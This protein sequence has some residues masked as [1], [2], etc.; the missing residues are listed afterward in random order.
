[1]FYVILL[2]LM[3]LAVGSFL[4]L[5]IDRLPRG[6]SIVR[7][8]S[9]CDS[10]NRR[11]A[12]SDLVPVFSYLWRRGRCHYCHARL[13]IR[14]PLVEITTGAAFTFLAWRYGITGQLGVFLVYTSLVIVIF[15][16][17]LETQL[18]LDRVLYPSLAL[19]LLFSFVVPGLG[20]GQA[21]LGSAIGLGTL[22]IPY[23]VYRQGMGF[24]DVKLG[25]LVGMMTGYPLVFVALLLAV[26]SGGLVAAFLLVLRLRGRREPVPFGPFLAT[27]ALIT[28]LWGDP[29]WT[30][31]THLVLPV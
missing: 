21:L 27:A 29:L 7:P 28:T 1:M 3:G 11:L 15:A 19:A 13:P 23:L 18:I 2:G 5:C 9:R 6:E 4:N 20:P 17:D 24:G 31:Y 22:S 12:P 16:I 25:A 30:W 26:L 14:L 8:P 10:C